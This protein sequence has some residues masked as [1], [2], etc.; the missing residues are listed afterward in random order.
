MIDVLSIVLSSCWSAAHDMYDVMIASL[1]PQ[2]GIDRIAI[3]PGPVDRLS[4]AGFHDHEDFS[5][6]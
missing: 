1:R 5:R 2:S 4:Q 6:Q 3:L